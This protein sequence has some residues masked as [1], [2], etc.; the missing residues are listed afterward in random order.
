MVPSRIRAAE[1]LLLPYVRLLIPETDA[2]YRAEILEFPGCI[3]TGDTVA[4]TLESLEDIAISWVEGALEN[5]QPIPVPADVQLIRAARVQA[6]RTIAA[7]KALGL[8]DGS[9]ARY[10]LDGA[11]TDIDHAGGFA[12]VV[13]M[14]TLRRVRGQL[15]EV[16]TALAA[17]E[18]DPT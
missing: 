1:Y 5:S 7:T 10:N 4:E 3:A 8:K 11:I 16:E 12:D 9:H 14:R 13:V 2:T 17:L 18:S 15:A 6:A